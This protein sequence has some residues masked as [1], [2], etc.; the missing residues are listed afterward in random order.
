M[1]NN[2]KFINEYFSLGN[3]DIKGIATDSRRT[4]P[5]DIYFAFKGENFDGHDYIDQSVNNGA[6]A[7]V[8]NKRWENKLASSNTIVITC[9]D[10]LAEYQNLASYYLKKISPRTIGITGSVG[11]TSQKDVLYSILSTALRTHATDGNFNNEYGVPQTILS[12]P[13]DTQVLILEMG[14]SGA[15]E[16]ARLVEI[17]PPDIAIIRNI[18]MSHRENFKDDDGIF[19]AK[20]EIISSNHP[21]VLIVDGDDKRLSSLEKSDFATGLVRVGSVRN[22]DILVEE[23]Y[24]ENGSLHFKLDSV[25]REFDISGK[26]NAI[27]IGIAKAVCQ[28]LGIDFDLASKGLGGIKKTAHRLEINDAGGVRIIDDTYNAAPDSMRE[29][30]DFLADQEGR[31]IAVLAD[32]L[33]L[34]DYSKLEHEKIGKYAIK[35][36]VDIL[37]CVGRLAKNIYYGGLSELGQNGASENCY[38]F[39]TKDD[40]KKLLISLL[41]R[42][43]HILFKGSNSMKMVELADWLFAYLMKGQV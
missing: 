32:M 36:G 34:G 4:K 20:M 38:Y 27:N 40:V 13:A 16:I 22:A 35:N 41:K 25:S 12:M 31:K 33:E 7:V 39:E 2:C 19:R 6:I 14:M 15:G 26:Y 42:G 18:G 1:S 24:Y 43:D 17:A 5:G 8:V 28:I 9:K 21:C 3:I 30:L 23:V 11:K 29:A 37:I 10:P